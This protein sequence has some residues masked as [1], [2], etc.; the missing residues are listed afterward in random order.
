[1]L[2]RLSPAKIIG[3]ITHRLNSGNGRKIR[4][5]R[6]HFSGY[7]IQQITHWGNNSP[8]TGNNPFCCSAA[9]SNLRVFTFK[10][11][12]FCDYCMCRI[13][14]CGTFCWR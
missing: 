6:N 2:K 10:T 12:D 9:D 13:N 8:T 14:P 1:I 3:T 11:H 7:Q 5:K 4:L